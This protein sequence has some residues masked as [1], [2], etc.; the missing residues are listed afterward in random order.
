MMFKRYPEELTEKIVHLYK[1]GMLITQISNELHINRR[2]VRTR[3]KECGL[4]FKPRLVKKFGD[5]R[6]NGQYYYWSDSMIKKLYQLFPNNHN[7][8]IAI[9][10]GLPLAAIERK[11]YKLG[12]KKNEQW[13]KELRACNLRLTKRHKVKILQDNRKML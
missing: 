12:L 10:M 7:N 5:I 8:D 1:G 4:S 9:I 3:L 2:T 11:A 6:V 13:L